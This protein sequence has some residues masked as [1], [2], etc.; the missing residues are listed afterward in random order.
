MAKQRAKGFP[1]GVQLEVGKWYKMA[2]DNIAMVT[3]LA[4]YSGEQAKKSWGFADC[5]DDVARLV[6]GVWIGSSTWSEKSTPRCFIHE[7]NKDG[8]DLKTSFVQ[9]QL[10]L[11]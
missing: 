9:L 10:D 7:C 6:S 3:K 5:S 11:F 8:S 1:D 2:N 4:P